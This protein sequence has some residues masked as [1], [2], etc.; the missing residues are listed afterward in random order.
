MT[1]HSDTCVNSEV[2]RYPTDSL[3]WKRFDEL[4]PNFA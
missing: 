4:N 3:A 1:W 2:L